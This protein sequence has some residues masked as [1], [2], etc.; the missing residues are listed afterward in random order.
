M[1]NVTRFEKGRFDYVK[2]AYIY[3]KLNHYKQML[4]IANINENLLSPYVALQQW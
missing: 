1:I 4:P 3:V 2:E